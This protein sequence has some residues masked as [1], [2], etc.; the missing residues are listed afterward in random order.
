[1]SQRPPKAANES[2]CAPEPTRR[3]V[4]AGAAATPLLPGAAHADDPA[5]E[6]SNTWLE[7]NA[8]HARLSKRWQ[9]IETR[10]FKDHNW[11][12]LTRAERK[13]F[14][15]KHEMDDLYDR[16]DVL[17]DENKVLLASLPAI[18]AISPAGICGKLSIAAMETKY[19]QQEIHAVI[20]SI[21]RDYRAVH[22]VA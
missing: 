12:K 4:L 13:R 1:M 19:D 2:A 22:G 8:E 20:L 9:K 14:P 18:I 11:P 3:L 21:L 16:M 5:A 7:R 6:A 17:H 10:M 15:E